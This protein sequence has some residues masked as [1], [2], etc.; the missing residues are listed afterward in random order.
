MRRLN[1]T[2]AGNDFVTDVLSFAALEEPRRF[3]LSGVTDTELGDIAICLPQAARQARTAGH[4]LA[5]EVDVLLTHGL[6]H[7]LGFDHDTPARERAMQRAQSRALAN[8]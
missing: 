5:V 3:R 4:S 8:R 7:L 1:R 6:L 2:Y